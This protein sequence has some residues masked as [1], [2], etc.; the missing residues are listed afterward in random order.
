MILFLMDKLKPNTRTCR[1]LVVLILK[2]EARHSVVK[3][4]CLCLFKKNINLIEK[5]LFA[6][7]EISI[8]NSI[9][10]V[11]SWR[12]SPSMCIKNRTEQTHLL[13]AMNC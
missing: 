1:L 7:D 4:N 13:V 2:L 6:E 3:Q 8:N 11:W 12:Q 5:I 10:F 9:T